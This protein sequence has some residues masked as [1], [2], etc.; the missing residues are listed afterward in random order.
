MN[1]RIVLFLFLSIL[2]STSIFGQTGKI[3]G[4]VVDVANSP[5]AGATVV[6]RNRSTGIEKTTATDAQ[7]AFSF[8]S[9]DAGPYD[10]VVSSPG[11]GTTTVDVGA[12]TSGLNI[13]LEPQPL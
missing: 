3:H 2:F 5:V 6:L 4:I 13:T 11:F 10:V 8:D 1:Y 12:S 9:T 7:G